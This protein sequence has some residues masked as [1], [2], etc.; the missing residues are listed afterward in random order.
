MRYGL[1]RAAF[2]VSPLPFPQCF[3][4]KYCYEIPATTDIVMDMVAK[5]HDPRVALVHQM[6]FT[7]DQKGLAAAVEKV[8]V[9]IS[10][11]TVQSEIKLVN[12]PRHN[13]LIILNHRVLFDCKMIKNE[14]YHY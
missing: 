13:F 7:T 10:I 2:G 12:V 4:L 6:P 9:L 5:M 11:F 14:T 8:R 3:K 1:A